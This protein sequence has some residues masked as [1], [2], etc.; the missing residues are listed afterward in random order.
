MRNPFRVT[1]AMRSRDRLTAALGWA[2]ASVS[3][4][5]LY[6][7]TRGKC[8]C[9]KS[10]CQSAGKHPIG[11]E[12]PHGHLDATHDP[13]R[14]KQI[15]ATYPNANVAIVP[16]GDF[17]VVDVDGPLGE[18]SIEAIPIPETPSVKTGRGRHLCFKT[19][20]ARPTQ[21]TSRSGLSSRR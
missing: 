4:L 13:D 12:F 3:V 21:E 17:I 6:G 15:F 20:K 10:D 1:E 7:V 14:I 8:D 5:A 16:D 19:D 9:G 11:A 2:D 18:A